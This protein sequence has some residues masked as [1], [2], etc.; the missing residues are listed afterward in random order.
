M[1]AGSP[2]GAAHLRAGRSGSYSRGVCPLRLVFHREE[3]QAPEGTGRERE[4]MN[5]FTALILAH[6]ILT[7]LGY[8]PL[9][10]GE[11]MV[12]CIIASVVV[13]GL[14]LLSKKDK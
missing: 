1:A 3:M 6:M 13:F 8:E 9:L 14:K 12:A 4:T 7:H 5:F 10:D 11:R 2:V